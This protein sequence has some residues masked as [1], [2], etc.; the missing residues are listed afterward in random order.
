[1]P[2]VER[3]LKSTPGISH[4][5]AG[6]ARRV[7][8]LDHA[9]SGELIVLAE[10]DSWFT[11][12]YWLDEAKRPDYADTVDI[13]RKPGYDPVEL[14]LD[15]GIKFPK[16][17]IGWTLAKRKLGL[18]PAMNVISTNAML[19]KGSHGVAPSSPD[20]SPLFLTNSPDHLR[21]ERVSPIS[22]RDLI[23]AHVM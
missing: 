7:I 23:L 20:R 3:E 2:L 17:K 11:Y 22:V 15:P 8:D 12:Y 10:P 21:S 5:Y 13:H 14:F 4:V 19:V 6:D 18:R 1:M 16:A 9:R